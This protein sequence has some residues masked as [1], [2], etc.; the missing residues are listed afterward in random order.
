MN[1]ARHAR[2]ADNH[3]RKQD[4]GTAT[5]HSVGDG[6]NVLLRSRHK[7]PKNRLEGVCSLPLWQKVPSL[8]LHEASCGELT[9]WKRP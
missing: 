1:R 5:C 7:Q 2:A 6:E 3:G 4:G 8:S 9:H